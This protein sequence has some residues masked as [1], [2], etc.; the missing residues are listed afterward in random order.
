MDLTALFHLL[1]ETAIPVLEISS[2]YMV[3]FL[4]AVIFFIAFLSVFGDSS[5]TD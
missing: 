1:L 4:A 3:G 2:V 5:D